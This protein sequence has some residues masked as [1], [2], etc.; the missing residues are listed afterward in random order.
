MSVCI[1]PV[2]SCI[3]QRFQ[4]CLTRRFSAAATRCKTKLGQ[5][6][7][8][9]C[10]PIS[11]QQCI[12]SA[13]RPVSQAQANHAVCFGAFPWQAYL[14]YTHLLHPQPMEPQAVSQS[15]A[16]DHNVI[17]GLSLLCHT[18]RT[19]LLHCSY[20]TCTTIGAKRSILVAYYNST[21]CSLRSH[22]ST[23]CLLP[24]MQNPAWPAQHSLAHALH[25]SHFTFPAVSCPIL[26]DGVIR[27]WL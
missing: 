5:H 12:C 6:C 3:L 18:S 16:L 9:A 19:N 22:V 2:W 1:N 11:T 8:A 10:R 23:L 17:K 15:A 20:F 14:L 4:Q 27:Q 24:A 13:A 21:A 26:T 7:Q 25:Y